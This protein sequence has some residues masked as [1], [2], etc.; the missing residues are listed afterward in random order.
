MSLKKHW[1][2]VY[3]NKPANEVSWFQPHAEKSLS[4]IESLKVPK[5]AR[6]ID[7]GGGASHLVDDLLV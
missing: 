4:I 5:N 3:T 1:E 6:I 2:N 7:V